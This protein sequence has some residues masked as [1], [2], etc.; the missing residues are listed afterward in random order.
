V[1]RRPRLRRQRLGEQAE[2]SLGAQPVDGGVEQGQRL[3]PGPGV[4]GGEAGVPHH[5]RLGAIRSDALNLGVDPLAGA[6]RVGAAEDH[7][8]RG[9]G[10]LSP[11]A[12]SGGD[13]RGPCLRGRVTPVAAQGDVGQGVQGGTR[14][15]GR[16]HLLGQPD[17][18]INRPRS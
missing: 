2:L 6:H 11:E 18:R 16:P 14:F 4:C 10:F 13:D 3:V 8:Q 15:A 1:D 12:L 7:Q 17:H 5:G 9:L